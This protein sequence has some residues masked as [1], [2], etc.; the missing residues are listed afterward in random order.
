RLRSFVVALCSAMDRLDGIKV[1]ILVA[2]QSLQKWVHDGT[3]Y[4]IGQA[5]QAYTIRVSR[6]RLPVRAASADG[7]MAPGQPVALRA[8]VDGKRVLCR[9][10][11][12]LP[13]WPKKSRTFEGFEERVRRTPLADGG[14]ERCNDLRS[15]E[16]VI[17]EGEVASGSEEQRCVQV[18]I[19]TLEEIKRKVSH[20]ACSVDVNRI[21]DPSMPTLT[22]IERKRHWGA[23]EAP[24][25]TR[26]GEARTIVS[27][28]GPGYQTD[29][30]KGLRKGDLLDTITIRY[31][32]R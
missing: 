7:R 29:V 28:S 24:I 9:E 19:W 30:E 25:A 18:E 11:D 23:G 17:P 13:L 15:F 31:V 6:A 10:A 1:D 8:F 3:E 2:Q 16:F 12:F 20:H 27:R 26:P 21:D 22:A 14:S 4:V 32:G 5:G